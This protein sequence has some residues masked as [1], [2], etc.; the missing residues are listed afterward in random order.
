MGHHNKCEKKANMYETICRECDLRKLKKSIKEAGLKPEVKCS[1]PITV[2]GPTDKAFKN[3]V[4]SDTCGDL[5]EILKYHIV[6]LYLKSCK[7]K[8]DT[9]YPTLRVK[10]G[11]DTVEEVRVNVYKCPTFKNVITVNGAKVVEADIKAK[12]G[13]LHKIDQVLCPPAGTIVEIA[14]S[15]PDFSVLVE[16]VLAADPA[17]LAAISNPD[18]NLTL[19]APTNAAFQS[20]ATELGLTL[21][22]LADFLKA[23]PDVLTQV[24]LY[25]TLGQTV[26]SAALRKGLT[27]D[28]ATLSSLSDN[29]IDI[30]KKCDNIK[31]ID[32]L[33]RKSEV[34][35]ADILAVNG[36]IHVIN[37]VLLPISVV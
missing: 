21:Q 2:F 37:K 1:C 30:C 28:I 17:V 12:N 5:E 4:P 31:V 13:V 3:F 11:F 33:N 26:F 22:E 34:V 9:K 25:H 6:P 14:L 32:N 8:N 10:E 7:L 20:L 27:K 29:T 24:L 15:N 35:G 23:N 18:A 16:L 19:F 36:V